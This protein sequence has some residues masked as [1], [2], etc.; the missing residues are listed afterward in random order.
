MLGK[1]FDAPISRILGGICLSLTLACGGL[2]LWGKSEHHRAD[3]WEAHSK[4]EASNHRQTKTNYR[5]AQATAARLEAQRLAAAT[6]RQEGITDAV[7]Q[8]YAAR[9]AALRARY[10]RLRAQSRAGAAGT[11]SGIAVPGIPE[12]PGRADGAADIRLAGA[13]GLEP[14]ERLR[15]AEQALQ[16]DALIDWVERQ[17]AADRKDGDETDGN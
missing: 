2:L 14:G 8:D 15:A 5:T 3:A 7:K 9:L 16:L 4:L 11:A 13:D 10:E 1:L 17:Q 12:T 6:A